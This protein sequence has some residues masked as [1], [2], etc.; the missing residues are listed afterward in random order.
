M[1]I[2][3]SSV[4]VFCKASDNVE[5]DGEDEHSI[6]QH[7][8]CIQIEAKKLRPNLDLIRQRLKRT[9]K[10]RAEYISQHSTKE[11]LC[12]FPCFRQPIF[13]SGSGCFFFL[14]RVKLAMV[15]YI[16][17]NYVSTV[18]FKKNIYLPSETGESCKL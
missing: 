17:V 1:L 12:Q 9:K 16:S 8:K 18:L 5:D 15:W 3:E 2:L 7:V 14:S 6:A 10:Y 13:V 4:V 11:V